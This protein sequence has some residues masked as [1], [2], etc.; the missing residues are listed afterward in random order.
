MND[1]GGGARG[2]TGVYKKKKTLAKCPRCEKLHRPKICW[3][4]P[5]IM[6]R[7]LCEN[8][9]ALEGQEMEE[10]GGGKTFVH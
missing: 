4:E 5:H 9:V 6:P 2:V 10:Y 8:C 3:A 7:L 1:D